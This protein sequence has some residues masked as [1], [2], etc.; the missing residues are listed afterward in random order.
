MMSRWKLW[1]PLAILAFIGGLS[2]YGLTAPKDEFVRSQMI[3]QK[4]PTFELPPATDGIKGLSNRDFADGKPRLLNFF[5]SWCAPCKM[6]APQLEAL[7]A[8]G[9]EIHGI[10][11]RDRPEDVASFLKQ[12]GNP[13]QRI[14][15]DVDMR[16]QV[17]F[18]SSGVPETYVISGDGRITYQHIGDIR[19]EHIP[20]LLEKLKEAR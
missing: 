19:S 6:E 9:V 15:A 8:A 1:L 4:L 14:G 7:A 13:F 12:Y 11:L 3:G 20:L 18:G 10:A 16:L 17:Q 2:L 5:G